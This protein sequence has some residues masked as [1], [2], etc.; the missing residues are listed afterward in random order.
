MAQGVDLYIFDQ[1]HLAFVVVSRMSPTSVSLGSNGPRAHIDREGNV[2]G[3]DP[4]FETLWGRSASQAV[5]RKLTQLLVALEPG[6]LPELGSVPRDGAWSGIVAL[7][8]TNGNAPRTT[9]IRL[10]RADAS[11]ALELQLAP[12]SVLAT[13][14]PTGDAPL[15]AGRDLQRFAALLEFMPGYCYTVDRDLTFTSSSGKGLAALNLRAGQVIGMNLR[16]LWGTREDTYEPLVCHLKALAGIA[17]TYK[18]VCLGRSLEYLIRPLR[19]ADGNVTGAIGVAVD[20]TDAEQA[21][22]DREKLT[23]QLRQAQRMEAIGRLAGGVAHDFNNFL[24]CIM[25]NLSLLEAHVAKGSDAE[26]FLAQAN[27][28]VDSAAAISRQLLAFSRKQVISPRPVDLSSLVERLHNILERLAGTRIRLQTHCDPELWSVNADAGQL[29]Q[30]LVNLVMNARD[31]ISEEGEIVIEARNRTLDMSGG[32]LPEPLGP[33]QYVV[34]SVTD[35]GRGLSDVERSRLFEPF[36]TTKELGEG[37][38]LGLA[39]VSGAV[40]ECGGAIT[41]ESELGK[42]S[43]FRILLPRVARAVALEAAPAAKGRSALAVTGGTETILLVEDEPLVLELAHRTLQQLGYNV[44]PC[45]SA[46]EALR[47]FGEYQSRIQ[48]VLTDLVMPRMNGKELAARIRAFS[49]GVPVLYS[50]GHG[51][52]IVAHQGASEGLH[53]IGKPYRPRELAAKVRQLLDARRSCVL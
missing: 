42:G 6:A 44:L 36:F 35:S 30:V 10:T 51:E 7:L 40:K 26:G 31:A 53:F 8:P 20:V 37:T 2:S 48:L 21:R 49:P 43:T 46:D 5:G 52:N 24:T 16:A 19:A 27:A 28:A 23:A 9:G 18:D 4:A 38:G 1:M 29:E 13:E 25:G 22:Q 32:Q 12:L 39:T 3:W 41:V 50:S 33:G 45:A 17:S 11:G 47:I 15:E 34:L 14:A